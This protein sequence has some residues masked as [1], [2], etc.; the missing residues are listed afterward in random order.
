MKAKAAAVLKAKNKVAQSIDIRALEALEVRYLNKLS[1][2][3]V[4]IVR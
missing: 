4:A 1:K 3:I 2:Q